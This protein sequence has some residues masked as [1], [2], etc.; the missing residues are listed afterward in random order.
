MKRKKKNNNNVNLIL[1][2]IIIL[3]VVTAILAIYY[4]LNQDEL[5]P[6]MKNNGYVLETSGKN[7]YKKI[8]TNNTLDDYYNDISNN[9]DSEYKEYYFTIDAKDFIELKL[10]QKKGIGKSI[11]ITSDLKRNQTTYTYEIT[12]K[13][14]LLILEG[15][16]DNSY[17]CKVVAKEDYNMDSV[18]KYCKEVQDEIREFKIEEQLLLNDVKIKQSI[19][20]NELS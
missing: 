4:Y 2:G 12:Q 17:A 14:K 9:K 16:S 11:T 6:E 8:V 5:K 13:D 18:T 3:T 20:N 1:Y 19:D 7:Y 15:S 10:S